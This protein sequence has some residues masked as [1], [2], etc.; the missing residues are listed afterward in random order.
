MI[1]AGSGPCRRLTNG[2]KGRFLT[3]GPALELQRAPLREGKMARP[4][5]GGC[6][7]VLEGSL[8]PPVLDPVGL[9]LAAV[10]T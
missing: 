10:L 7:L 1:Q 3:A 6:R 8:R 5:G 4:A 2:D 9:A